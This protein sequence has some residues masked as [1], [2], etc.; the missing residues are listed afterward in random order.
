MA[1]TM[2][3]LRFKLISGDCGAVN[4]KNLVYHTVWRNLCNGI[5]PAFFRYPACHR[6]PEIIIFFFYFKCYKEF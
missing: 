5:R 6:E 1:L 4:P 2:L 3:Q